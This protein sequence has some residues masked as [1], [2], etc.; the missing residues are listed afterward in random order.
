MTISIS[1]Q[2]AIPSTFLLSFRN[3]TRKVFRLFFKIHYYCGLLRSL[4]SLFRT[5]PCRDSVS[6]TH[7][8]SSFHNFSKHQVPTLQ[9]DNGDVLTESIV[10]AKYLCK[11][12]PDC[13]IYSGDDC[14]LHNLMYNANTLFDRCSMRHLRSRDR[15]MITRNCQLVN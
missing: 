9:L 11:L 14:L 10:I 6:I 13:E 12:N 8:E 7:I 2:A 1:Y 3:R 4:C 15:R 5:I